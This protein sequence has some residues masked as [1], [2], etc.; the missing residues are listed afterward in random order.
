VE[1]I[2]AR[3]S[4]GLRE[5]VDAAGHRFDVVRGESGLLADEVADR[6]EEPADPAAA[7]MRGRQL[8]SASS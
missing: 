5:R 6:M 4:L 3:L 1:K 7:V 2:D 8:L